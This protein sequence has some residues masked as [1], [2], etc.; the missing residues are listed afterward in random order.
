VKPLFITAT[1]TGIGKTIVTTALAWQAK[2]AGKSVRVL[3]PV[4]SGFTEDT[5]D[6]SDTALILKSLGLEETE[7]AISNISPWRYEAPLAPDMAAARENTAL[8]F[9]KLI[10]CCTEAAEGPDDIVL[11]EGVGG[12]M[13]PLTETRTVLDWIKALGCSSLLVSGSYLGTIS[14]TLTA[15]E[16]AETHG[17]PIKAIIISES[18]ESPV[19]VAETA[20]AIGR[21][22]PGTPVLELPRLPAGLEQWRHA[23]DLITKIL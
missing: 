10:S 7:D 20:A 11:I 5:Y 12:L 19:P 13:V 3:K 6:E 16:T 9:E 22:L 8:D 15:M 17:L 4:I 14:H 2:R 18:E 21:F 23:P 1:G